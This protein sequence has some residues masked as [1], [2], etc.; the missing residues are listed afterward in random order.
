MRRRLFAARCGQ[1]MVEFALG[2]SLLMVLTTGLVDLGRAVW[3]YNTVSHL[4]REGA[5]YGVVPSRSIQDIKNYICRDTVAPTGR[6][7][8]AVDSNGDGRCEE[9]SNQHSLAL[10]MAMDDFSP[11]NVR[12]GPLPETNPESRGVCGDHNSPVVVTVKH[13]FQPLTAPLWGAENNNL[14]LQATSQMYIEKG[15]AGVGA[16]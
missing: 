11:N 7:D 4:A 5:R 3:V 13:G 6:C 8:C 16:C 10:L 1:N 9:Y 12:V 2:V 14:T 15:V